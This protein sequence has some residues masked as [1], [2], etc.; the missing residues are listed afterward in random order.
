VTAASDTAA[1]LV[2]LGD[3][4]PGRVQDDDHGGVRNVHTDFDDGGGDDDVQ[5]TATERGHRFG[6][7]VR[8]Q[9]A[10]HET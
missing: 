9:L 2:Q 1:Q 10:V 4:E 8:F 7:F 5:V 3:T 6:S